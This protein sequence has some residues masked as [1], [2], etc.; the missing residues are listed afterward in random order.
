MFIKKKQNMSSKDFYEESSITEP[1]IRGQVDTAVMPTIN[2]LRNRAIVKLEMLKEIKWQIEE[3][4][5]PPM[6][7][8]NNW[9]KT[10]ETQ[11]KDWSV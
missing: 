3:L 9:I 11:I 5:I 2:E 10:I 6:Q 4:K 7:V 1:R 8:I